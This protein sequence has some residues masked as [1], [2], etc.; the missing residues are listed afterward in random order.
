[1]LVLLEGGTSKMTPQNLWILE[2]NMKQAPLN[3]LT[4]VAHGM[5]LIN[6]GSLEVGG[7]LAE[8]TKDKWVT[9]RGKAWCFFQMVVVSRRVFPKAYNIVAGWGINDLIRAKTVKLTWKPSE[10][11]FCSFAISWFSGLDLVRDCR[12]KRGGGSTC[13]FQP[14]DFTSFPRKELSADEE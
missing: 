13:V 14:E 11:P 5:S 3:I 7:P 9:F 2:V 1:M 10:V 8:S 4:T 6:G 12:V